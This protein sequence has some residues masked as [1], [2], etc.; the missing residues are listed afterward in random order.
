MITVLK[1]GGLEGV[2]V[3]FGGF[4]AT[5]SKYRGEMVQGV[6]RK[7]QVNLQHRIHP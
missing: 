2:L 4:G 5:V 1:H 7:N 3:L 6:S